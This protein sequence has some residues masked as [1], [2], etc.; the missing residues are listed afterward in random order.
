MVQG[1]NLKNFIIIA[2]FIFLVIGA[3][4][5][6]ARKNKLSD[7]TPI[8]EPVIKASNVAVD[9]GDLSGCGNII[10]KSNK[11]L[12]IVTAGHILDGCA[13]SDAD[14]VEVTFYDGAK[15]KAKVLK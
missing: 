5:G 11:A 2:L 14:P 1:R 3:V 4:L 7:E 12:I 10:K 9:C 8:T 6:I 15:A 13:D